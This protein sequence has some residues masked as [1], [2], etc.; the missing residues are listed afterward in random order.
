M[1]QWREALYTSEDPAGLVTSNQS[2]LN[3]SP[4]KSSIFPDQTHFRK[5]QSRI[6][7]QS[8]FCG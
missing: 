3:E 7:G 1:A 6:S 2:E 4:V 5:L 8:R